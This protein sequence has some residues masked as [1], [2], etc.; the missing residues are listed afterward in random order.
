LRIIPS[1]DLGGLGPGTGEPVPYDWH[2]Y[3]SVPGL[4]LWV[5]LALAL[6]AP[7]ANRTP[8]VVWILAPV[9]LVALLW[10]AIAWISKPVTSDRVMFGAMALSL[11]VGSAVLWLLGHVLAQRGRDRALVLALGLALGIAL[12]GASWT[13]DFTEQTLGFASLLVVLMLTMVLGYAPAV[14]LS[15]G[16]YRPVKFLLLLGAGT[17]AFSALGMPL[18]FLLSSAATG[19]WPTNIPLV[20]GATVAGGALMGACVFLV[21]LLFILVGLRRPLLRPRFFACLGLTIA[22]DASTPAPAIP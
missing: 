15:R 21:S 7:K 22:P 18:W 8:G 12:V 5:V 6:V 3:Y 10:L 20:L 13:Q 9:L 19:H 11:A 17:V 1:Y 16:V 14:H 2:W 4:G